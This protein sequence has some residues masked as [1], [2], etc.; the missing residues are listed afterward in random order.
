MQNVVIWTKSD[1]VY[2]EL[3]K[4]LLNSREIEYNEVKITE[5]TRAQLLELV[6]NAKS[7]P[8]III[9]DTPIGGYNDLCKLLNENQ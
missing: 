2:C 3:A 5:E 7:A 8:Q 1:C 4:A 9:D 6:P